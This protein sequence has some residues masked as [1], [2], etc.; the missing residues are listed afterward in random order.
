[1]E[2]P[3][4]S[5]PSRLAIV[6]G[7][8]GYALFGLFLV[9]V[10][11]YF[12]LYNARPVPSLVQD[13]VLWLFLGKSFT[14]LAV[15]FGFSFFAMM[16]SAR[17]RGEP[18]AGRFAWRLTLLFAIGL[19]HALI[20]RGDIIVVLAAAGFLLIPF[21]HVRSTRTLLWFAAFLL[22]QPLLIVRIL[23]GLYG[24][25]WALAE[26]FFYDDGG[27][28]RPSLNGTFSELIRANLIAGNTSKWSFYVETGR[29]VQILGLYLIGLVLGRERFFG[30]PERFRTVR[31]R[32][33]VVAVALL[34]P[35]AVARDFTCCRRAGP[36]YW[37][38]I[39][40]ASWTDL[41]GMAITL[42]LFVELWHSRWC[43]ILRPLVPAGRMTLTLYISQSLIFVPVFYGFG[44]HLW[45]RITQPEAL[46]LGLTAFAVQLVFATIWFRY[47]V[48]GPFEW[49]WRAATKLSLDVPFRRRA[50]A[51]KASAT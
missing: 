44:L 48:Y 31:R 7:L 40:L 1:M 5:K 50:D 16:D 29:M 14:L 13:G 10:T 4:I 18:F 8:R 35:L 23:A 17:R 19:I 2:A 27:A 9:H 38:D 25:P 37:T 21:D 43:R 33:L 41:A 36:V 11:G 6:D 34:V 49:V 30:G 12:E 15:C 26:P 42:I 32:I 45:D 47:F 51:L 3:P 28:M 46:W 22:A 20:Y 39:M 24:A